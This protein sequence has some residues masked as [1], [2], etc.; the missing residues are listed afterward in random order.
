MGQEL[1]TIPSRE[2][3]ARST[4]L[5]SEQWFL[6]T[7]GNFAAGKYNTMTVS[8]GSLGYI[9]QKPFV[10][11]VVRPSRH[12]Y[13]F[14]E[15]FNTFT[16]CGLPPEF[17]PAMQILGSKSGR[18]GDKI[19][20]SGLTVVPAARVAAPVYAEAQLIIECR[21]MYFQDLDPAHFLDP[22]IHQQYPQPNY[23]RMYFGEILHISGIE[24]YMA[25]PE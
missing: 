15:E 2:F 13:Q 14:M 11:V 4:S 12:T 1:H 16:L 5:W 24:K 22:E 23:H 7:C 17:Q 8:W 25:Q 20:A 9:W 6:L 21:K 3:L 19:T 18:D 10:M